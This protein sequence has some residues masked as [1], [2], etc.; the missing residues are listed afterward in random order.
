MGDAGLGRVLERATS[1]GEKGSQVGQ[2]G[3]AA[4]MVRSAA[5]DSPR[6][7]EDPGHGSALSRRGAIL[8]VLALEALLHPAGCGFTCAQ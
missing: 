5:Q 7:L 3:F 4:S 2:E 8:A 1:G 6:R